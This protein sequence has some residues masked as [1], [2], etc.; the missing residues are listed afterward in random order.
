MAAA[1][2]HLAQLYPGDE[3][4]DLRILSIN[5][6]GDEVTV[7]LADNSK[8]SFSGII[9]RGDVDVS[10]RASAIYA[11]REMDV[12]MVLDTT[13]SMKGTKMAALKSAAGDMI[14]T[15]SEQN[16]SNIR[17]SVVPFSNHVNVGLSQRN[18]AWLNVPADKDTRGQSCGW[19]QKT[20]RY[21]CEKYT[22]TCYRDGVAKTCTKTRNCKTRKVGDPVYKCSNTGGI[23]RWQG[24]VGSRTEPLDM[25]VTYAGQKIPGLRG[26]PCGSEILPLTTNLS[27]VSSSIKGLKPKGD[28][29]LPAGLMWGWRA[30]DSNMP[31]VSAPRP[32]SEK[33][34]ILMTDGM[35]SVRKNGERHQ[36]SGGNSAS[37][38]ALV[39]ADADAKTKQLCDD[40][41]DQGIT[42]YTI[43]YE[44]TDASTK[45]MLEQCASNPSQYF[46]A[47]SAAEL[48]KAF[49]DIGNSL[50]ELR[51]TA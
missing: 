16:N 28:T 31:L 43:A 22:A 6:V 20:E 48:T 26:K 34:M 38:R 5:K 2:T 29:Y 39:K 23:S 18:K 27:T 19:R 46:D 35:N 45:T 12:A 11:Q 50:N 33:V 32:D 25:Q 30:L 36:D 13:D 47:D 42:M 37:K 10:A 8:S 3:G 15:L 41:K 17:M 21:G 7:R 9:G 49:R 14:D 44:V 1:Q 4:A 24:C 40:M 51:I